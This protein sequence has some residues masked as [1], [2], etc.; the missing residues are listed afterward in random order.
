MLYIKMLKEFIANEKSKAASA[1][2]QYKS[3]PTEPV[4]KG[5]LNRTAPDNGLPCC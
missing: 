3:L 2:E 4:S 1:S 5:D